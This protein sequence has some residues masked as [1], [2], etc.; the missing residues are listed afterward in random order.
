MEGCRE[1]PRMRRHRLHRSS[2]GEERLRRCTRDVDA[3]FRGAPPASHGLPQP[4]YARGG[5]GAAGPEA[6]G[7][8]C[9]RLAAQPPGVDGSPSSLGRSDDRGG[10]NAVPLQTEHVIPSSVHGLDPSNHVACNCT[11]S[12]GKVPNWELHWPGAHCRLLLPPSRMLQ[13]NGLA[14]CHQSI[15]QAINRAPA[16][17]RFHALPRAAGPGVEES[18]IAASH[19]S[20]N[21]AAAISNAP[22]R[23]PPAPDRPPLNRRRP[24]LSRPPKAAPVR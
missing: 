19:R 2:F 7:L 24:P 8:P 12:V 10:S 22:S 21:H 13:T 14:A 20:V 3:P 9:G 1:L 11:A 6:R 18:G 23:L 15:N 17:P 4:R 5:G 16:A